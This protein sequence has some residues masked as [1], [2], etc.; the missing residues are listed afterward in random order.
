MQYVVRL[1]FRVSIREDERDKL[2][3][4]VEETSR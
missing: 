2:G 3:A 4:G 1:G